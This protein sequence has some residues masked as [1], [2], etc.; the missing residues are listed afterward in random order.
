MIGA[1]QAG[2]SSYTVLQNQC[3]S[4]TLYF[5]SSVYQCVQGVI[6]GVFLYHTSIT[7]ITHACRKQIHLA[8]GYCLF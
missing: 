2:Y 4:I 3:H 7:C 5:V 6:D 8:K 1:R